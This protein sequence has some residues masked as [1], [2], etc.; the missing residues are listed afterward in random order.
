MKK[1][2]T[3]II[4]VLCLCSSTL[5]GCAKKEAES[6]DGAGNDKL[7]IVCTI[8]PE[9]D[10]MKQ[11]LGE[12]QENV[13]LTLIMDNGTDLHNFQPTTADIAEVAGCDMFVY[14]G[15]ESDGWVED[16]LK[17][18]TNPD[19]VVINLMEVLSDSIKEEEVVEGMQAEEEEEAGEEEGEEEVEYDEHVWLSLKNTQ[20]IVKAMADAMKT[21]DAAN[22]DTYAMNADSYIGQLSELDESYQKMVDEAAHK[23]VLFGD[24]FPFRYL[25]DDYGIEYYAAFVGCSAETEASFDTIVFLAGKVDELGLPTV[26]TIEN[27]DQAI[28]KT[29]I[30]NTQSKDQKILVLDS[31]Q[32]V[33]TEDISNGEEY[34]SIMQQNFEVLKEAL[35]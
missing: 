1:K 9:Y 10:W 8:F 33:T 34:L 35:N 12:Q 29:I 21:L 13:N 2:I 32:S 19:M 15:G 27:S 28:E 17:T 14:V 23:V 4:L 18:A 16:A 6:S 30:E 22:T 3:S 31:M 24:R 20:N 26:M 5:F 11:I 7:N 25:V